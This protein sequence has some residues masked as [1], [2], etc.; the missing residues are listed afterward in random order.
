[1]KPK[2]KA[3]RI[4]QELA[5]S[6]INP[7]NDSLA[8]MLVDIDNSDYYISRAK[9]LL[10]LAEYHKKKQIKSRRQYNRFDTDQNTKSM[11]DCV[12]RAITC[13]ALYNIKEGTD[14]LSE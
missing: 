14:G 13:L 9:E 7:S 5:K 8:K 11:H 3:T 6:Q 1:M 12:R 4:K 2:I 10:A